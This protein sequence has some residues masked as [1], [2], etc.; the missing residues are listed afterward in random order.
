M[1][2][3][4]PAPKNPA[5]INISSGSPFEPV[6][7]FC[8]AVAVGDRVFV[9]GSAPIW[10]DG[11]VNPDPEA[12]ATRCIDIIEAAL[13]EAGATLADVVRTRVYLTDVAVFEAV[14]RG[15]GARF[16]DIR[17]ANTTVVVSALLNPAW[18]VEIEAEAVIGARA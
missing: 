14:A 1:V 12:Q 8:R 11:S 7:G 13:V 2:T 5:R 15:H 9:S 10:P 3:N 6:M 18:H 17:P 4:N 16:A